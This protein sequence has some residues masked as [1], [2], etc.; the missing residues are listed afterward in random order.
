MPT[1]AR[2]ATW[3][4]EALWAFPAHLVGS[5][6]LTDRK[7]LLAELD[8][9]LKRDLVERPTFPTCTGYVELKYKLSDLELVLTNAST[10]LPVTGYF[11]SAP[12][13]KIDSGS[14]LRWFRAHWSPVDGQLVRND[15]YREWS[16]LDPAYR[17]AQVHGTPAVATRGPGRKKVCVRS[18]SDFSLAILTRIY[19]PPSSIRVLT[20]LL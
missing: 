4:F 12:T 6:A 9:H 3:R 11:Q 10:Q 16:R 5:T 17:H 19:I 14:L 7:C 20:Y 13:Q 1:D 2:K 8:S 15:A 18:F